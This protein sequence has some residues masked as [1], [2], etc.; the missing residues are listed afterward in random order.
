ML[1][2]LRKKK[3]GGGATKYEF[4][5]IPQREWILASFTDLK[6][7]TLTKLGPCLET[8]P[9][10]LTG[11]QARFEEVHMRVHLNT[12]DTYGAFN[13]FFYLLWYY[14]VNLINSIITFILNGELKTKIL[15]SQV[16]VY[17]IHLLFV[18]RT[19]TIYKRWRRK[20]IR[21]TSLYFKKESPTKKNAVLG[22]SNNRWLG[23]GGSRV[24]IYLRYDYFHVTLI[25]LDGFPKYK[26]KA[27]CVVFLPEPVAILTL[28]VG[29]GP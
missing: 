10:P 17:W 8:C 23:G 20:L 28:T 1:S 29:L 15:H 16:Q 7:A 21:T 5:L 22:F 26:F 19:S 27:L 18:V 4:F 2:F 25:L 14:N 6:R 3:W 13:P 9:Q 12:R 24:L 11:Y